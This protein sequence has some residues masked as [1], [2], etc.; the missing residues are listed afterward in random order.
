LLPPIEGPPESSG[1]PPQSVIVRWANPPRP[2]RH[3]GRL[4]GWAESFGPQVIGKASVDSQAFMLFLDRDVLTWPLEDI[5]AVQPSSATL[6]IHGGA[7]RLV[8]VRFLEDSVRRWEAVL[9]RTIQNRVRQLGRG[10]VAQFHP[11]IRYQ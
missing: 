9:H 10:E 8:S 5:T 4:L 7:H 2:V 3:R 6:Q 11:R 1:L